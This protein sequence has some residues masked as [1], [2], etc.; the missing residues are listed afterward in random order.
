MGTLPKAFWEAFQEGKYPNHHAGIIAFNLE[1]YADVIEGIGYSRT[2][3]GSDFHQDWEYFLNIFA[4]KDICLYQC[5]I[6][7]IQKNY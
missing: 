7:R 1:R 3:Y 2:L 5:T 6:S 4:F